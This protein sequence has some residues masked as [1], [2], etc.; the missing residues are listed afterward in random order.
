MLDNRHIRVH[1]PINTIPHAGLLT[2]VQTPTADFG[3]D[4][5]AEAHVCERVDGL[6]YL[7]FL[8]YDAQ[9]VSDWKRRG[10]E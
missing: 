10:A 1:V 6:L 8:S 7:G 9:K 2:P 5:L 3:G 4:A